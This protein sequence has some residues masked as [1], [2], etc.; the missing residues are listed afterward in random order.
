MAEKVDDD[1]VAA[2]FILLFISILQIETKRKKTSSKCIYINS[3]L[4]TDMPNENNNSA[5]NRTCSKAE[6]T[7][8]Q[9][10]VL[11]FEV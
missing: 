9:T 2:A 5:S 10:L 4:F 7:L 11:I 8:G 3:V 1:A 6:D